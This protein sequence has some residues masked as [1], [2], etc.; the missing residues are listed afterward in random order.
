M[1]RDALLC[2]G[3]ENGRY[4]FADHELQEGEIIVYP[5]GEYVVTK[6]PNDE[7]IGVY[8]AAE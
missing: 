8:R 2:D 7:L 5:G 3:P 1:S 4:H 6:W